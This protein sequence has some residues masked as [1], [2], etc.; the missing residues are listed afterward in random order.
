[1]R[2]EPSQIRSHP[3]IEDACDGCILTPVRVNRLER[4]AEVANAET[5]VGTIETETPLN[6]GGGQRILIHPPPAEIN[7]RSKLV[8]LD[9]RKNREVL[10]R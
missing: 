6:V 9:G 5:L 7:V 8:E 1:M 2:C 3:E 4:G 10:Q